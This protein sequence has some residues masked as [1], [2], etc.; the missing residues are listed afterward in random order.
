M[1]RARALYVDGKCAHMFTTTSMSAN[2]TPENIGRF[3]AAI[4]PSKPGALGAS[5]DFYGAVIPTKAKNPELAEEFIKHW[6][7]YDV[8]QEYLARTVVGWVPMMSDA[9]SDAYLNHPRI[10][11]V[12]DF[13]DIGG[14][15]SKKWCCWHRLLR[16]QQARIRAHRY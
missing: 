1:S 13:I 9:Y 16:T 15:G 4:Y 7:S 5:L 8:F 10:S 14:Q 12:G 2:F 3:G 6:L 11:L